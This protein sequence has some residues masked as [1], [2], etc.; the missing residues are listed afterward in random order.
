MREPVA[1]PNP[2]KIVPGAVSTPAFR[3]PRSHGVIERKSEAKGALL[4][5]RPGFNGPFD[6]Y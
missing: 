3:D 2:I 5:P 4:D 6:T 1:P